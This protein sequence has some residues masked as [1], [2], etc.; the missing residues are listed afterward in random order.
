MVSPQ[1]KVTSQHLERL[2]IVYPR[3]ST[4]RQVRQ[5]IYSTELQYGLSEQAARLGWDPQRILTLDADLG[6]SGQF[7]D[8]QGRAGFKELVA[9]GAWAKSGRSSGL[10]SP[11][12]RAQV[13]RP[14]GCLSTAR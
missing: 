3:Q 6:V 7:T 10:T 1:Q 13:R 11:G 4:P 5:N 12:W 8:G 2:A 9:R 14:S